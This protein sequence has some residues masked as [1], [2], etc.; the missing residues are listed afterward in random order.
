MPITS[1]LMK[2]VSLT[3]TKTFLLAL[4]DQIPGGLANFPAALIYS[5]ASLICHAL[6]WHRF[7]SVSQCNA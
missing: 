6:A 2:N 4:C 3:M 5:C 1:L 7:L